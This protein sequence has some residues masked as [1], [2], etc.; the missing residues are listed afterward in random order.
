[1]EGNVGHA[2]HAGFDIEDNY[3]CTCRYGVQLVCY[4]LDP[5]ELAIAD[6]LYQTSTDALHGYL[7]SLGKYVVKPSFWG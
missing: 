5:G 6:M 1:M 3:A 2:D 4:D 7:K